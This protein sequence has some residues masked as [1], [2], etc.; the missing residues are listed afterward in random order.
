MQKIKAFTIYGDEITI[1]DRHELVGLTVIKNDWL[2]TLKGAEFG[3]GNGYVV[4]NRLHPAYGIKCPKCINIHGGVTY[5][6]KMKDE[7]IGN[8]YVKDGWCFGFNT[9]HLGD[10]LRKWTKR[11]VI[12]ETMLLAKQLEEYNGISGQIDQ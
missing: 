5:S 2:E 11:A 10:S 1:R 3:W 12:A 4:V 9:L 8:L 7:N 6:E